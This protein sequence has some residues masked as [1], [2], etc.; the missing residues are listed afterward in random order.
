VYSLKIKGPLH[1][2]GWFRSFEEHASVDLNGNP[3]PYLTYPAVKFLRRRIL[4]DMSVFEYGSGA[5][6]LWWAA[7]VKEVVACEHDR[8]W[9]DEISSKAPTNV[10][11]I[12]QELEPK[13]KYAREILEFR[14]RFD[15]VVIDG[16][17]RVNCARNSLNALKASGIILWDNADYTEDG[18]GYQFL[19]DHGFRKVEFV[20]PGPIANEEW[21]TAIFYRSDNCL[22]I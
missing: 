1:D 7:R 3:V 6:T 8:N 16:R 14:D 13:G 5:S 9:Y 21:E 11:L 2:H 20:G 4:P 19:F 12:F 17:D 22:D 15:I 18:A 10:T